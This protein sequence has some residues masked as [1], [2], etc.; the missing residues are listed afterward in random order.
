MP[1]IVIFEIKLC[2]VKKNLILQ[3]DIRH[4]C[5]KT[6]NLCNGKE[7]TDVS[8]INIWIRNQW[9]MKLWSEK[10]NIVRENT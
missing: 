9:K 8:M 2:L 10:I 1:D 5:Q 6:C 7:K 3:A 4:G